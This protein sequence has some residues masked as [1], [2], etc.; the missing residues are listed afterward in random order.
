MESRAGPA[1]GA[2]IKRPHRAPKF[3]GRRRRSERN[4]IFVPNFSLRLI[5]IFDK[6]PI[7]PLFYLYL[8]VWICAYLLRSYICSAWWLG[9]ESEGWWGHSRK[10]YNRA[11]ELSEREELEAGGRWMKSSCFVSADICVSKK[12]FKVNTDLEVHLSVILLFITHWL[13]FQHS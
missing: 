6:R 13:L 3:G 7:S 11:L 5:N 10:E 2:I 8:F 4:G 9:D 1:L 12:M